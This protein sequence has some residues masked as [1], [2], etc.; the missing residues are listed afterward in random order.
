MPGCNKVLYAFVLQIESI[1][2]FD[3]HNMLFNCSGIGRDGLMSSSCIVV[4]IKTARHS[5]L[6]NLFLFIDTDYSILMPTSCSPSWSRVVGMAAL[7]LVLAW[8]VCAVPATHAQDLLSEFEDRVTTFTLDNGLTFVVVE[9]PEAPVVSFHTYADVGSV[10]EPAGQTGMAHMLEHM[11]FKGTTRIGTT[12]IDQEVAVLNELEDIYA[13]IQRE[14]ARHT[15]N[16]ERLSELRA[17]FDEVEERADSFMDPGAYDGLLEREGVSG[18]NAYTSA[19]ATGYLYSL[20]ANRLELFFATESER[21]LYPVMREF[22]TERDVV[23]EERLQR[24]ESNPVGRLLEEFVTTAYK[25]HPYGNPVIGHRADIEAYTATESHEFFERFYPASNLTIGMAG[26]VDPD[27]ARALAEKYFERL[28]GGDPPMPVHTTEPE[29]QGERRVTIED[30]SQPIMIV[31]YHRGSMFDD[32]HAVYRVLQDV[33]TRG[34]T[35]RLYQ[36]L[37]DTGDALQVQAI[38]SYPGSKYPSLFALLGV[39]S[40]DTDPDDLEQ[41]IYD[42]I[43]RLIDDGITEKELERAKTR[44]RADLVQQLDSNMGLAQQFAQMQALTGDW[45]S[46]FRDIEAIE[47]VTAD[48]VQ[49]VA[50]ETFV[51][52]NRTVATI[53]SPSDD[54]DAEEVEADDVEADVTDSDYASPNGT[55]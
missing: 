5:C 27:E 50:A 54:E 22:Y 39:P 12:D 46:V 47:A 21:F 25:A 14:E 11:L 10:D 33:L 20:P 35:S 2:F 43:N 32:D 15:P 13:Q 38:P 37:V 45:R 55:E 42:E 6:K 30:Q 7:G 44:A 19:D 24:T 26:D 52:S 49:R 8:A 53:V 9:R 17:S 31:G 36:S 34:R 1:C 48:D 29:Q 51:K 23:L 40:Q 28:P 41:A 16:E 3:P 4:A 18:L